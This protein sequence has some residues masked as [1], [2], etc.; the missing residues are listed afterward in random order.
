MLDTLPNI[1]AD[2]RSLVT[3]R[4][5]SVLSNATQ[6][7]DGQQKLK[8]IK[9]VY[10][11][12][13]LRCF[14]RVLRHLDDNVIGSAGPIRIDN[15]GRF[16]KPTR[17]DINIVKFPT[18]Y[19]EL[20]S[21]RRRGKTD[22]E[23]YMRKKIAECSKHTEAEEQIIKKPILPDDIKKSRKGSVMKG[24]D[25]ENSVLASTTGLAT[26]FELTHAGTPRKKSKKRF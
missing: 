5:V 7:N 4:S 22:P 2:Q 25:K 18:I 3:G 19:T 13:V 26:I 23:L 16:Y 10:S 14:Q 21:M 6:A 17:N 20:L 8:S 15:A 24:I 11:S 12:E 1:N 9:F